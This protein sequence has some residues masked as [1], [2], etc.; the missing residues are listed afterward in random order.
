MCGVTPCREGLGQ[1]SNNAC[2]VNFIVWLP[3][4]FLLTGSLSSVTYGFLTQYVARAFMAVMLL[5]GI[6]LKGFKCI[7]FVCA[8]KLQV[9]AAIVCSPLFV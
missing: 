6:C 2:G 5:W 7:L 3:K 9:H 1:L 8:I 4:H